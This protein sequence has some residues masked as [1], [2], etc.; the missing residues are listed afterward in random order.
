MKSFKG[1]R[2]LMEGGVAPGKLEVVKTSLAVARKYAEGLFNKKGLDIDKE[3]PKF[4]ENYAK[5]Q[6]LVGMGRTKRKDMPVIEIEDVKKLQYRLEHGHIDVEEPK[7]PEFKKNP[8]PEG[9]SGKTAQAWLDSGLHDKSFDDDRVKVTM[10]TEVVSNLKPIQKQIYFDKSMKAS[11]DNGIKS[12]IN[13]LKNIS[14]LIC[15][16]D[17]FIID[18]HHRYLSGIIIDHTMKVKVI[19]IDLPIKELL[20]LLI[21]YGDSIGNKRNL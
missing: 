2:I 9:L 12:T 5:V 8:F 15:S 7:N 16:S 3:I 13:F 21:S 10:G 18:G 11:V 6:S 14:I 1:F 20:P 4:D 17:N 19:K